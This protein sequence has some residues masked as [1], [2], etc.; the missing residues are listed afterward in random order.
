MIFERLRRILLEEPTGPLRFFFG[1]GAIG[2]SLVLPEFAT[3]P[4]YRL[5]FEWANPWVWTVAFAVN[6]WAMVTGALLSNPSRIMYLLEAVLGVAC[7]VGLGVATSLAQGMP[8]P[9]FFAS[10]IAVWLYVRYPEW[11]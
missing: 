5:A 9:T 6:G 8:G 11:N 4:M 10:F 3:Y 7:W 2:Y 1:F